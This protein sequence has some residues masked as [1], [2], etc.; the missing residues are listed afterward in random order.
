LPFVINDVEINRSVFTEESVVFVHHNNSKQIADEIID[1]CLNPD[2]RKKMSSNAHSDV[3]KVSDRV[4]SERYLNLMKSLT[5]NHKD[6]VV[7]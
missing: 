5:I 2:R 3:M 7:I 4:M 1:L 6:S